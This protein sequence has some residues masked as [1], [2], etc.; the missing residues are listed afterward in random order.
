MTPTE[1]SPGTPDAEAPG[2]E[3]AALRSRNRELEET[4]D[5]LQ[6]G[7]LDAIVVKKGGR[8]QVYTLEGADHPYRVLVEN[9]Q[10]GAL[11][12]TEEGMVLY[13]NTAFAAMRGRP[14]SDLV[15]TLLR[16]QVVPRDRGLF[17]ALLQRSRDRPA[18]CELRICSGAGSVPVLV[19][20]TPIVVN[21]SPKLSVVVSDRKEDYDRLLLQSRMLDA[22]GDAVIATDPSGRIIY[23]S[24]S[25]ARLYGWH[26][27][28]AIGRGLDELVV[29][30]LSPGDAR[31]RDEQLS[32]GEAWSGEYLV[33]RRDGHRFPVLATEAP[34][35]SE[36][37]ELVAVIGVSRDISERKG[38][39]AALR[40]SEERQALLAEVASRL[41]SADEPQA[42]IDDLC[43]RALGALDCDVFFNY[44]ADDASGRLPLNACGGIPA[45]EAARIR[46]LDYGAAV[47]GCVARD[48]CRSVAEAIPEHPDPRTDLVAAYG[49]RAYACHPLI[50][51][52]TPIGTLSFGTVSRDR[53]AADELATMQAIADLIA[54]ALQR[55]AGREALRANEARLRDVLEIS[56]DAAYRRDLVADRYDYLSP[57]IQEIAGYTAEEFAALPL[58]GVMA[59][60][61]P[62]DRP[63]ALAAIE[64]GAAGGT[65]TVEYRLRHRDGT[66]R[67]IQDYFVVQRDADGRP[68][69][70]G[71]VIR[72]ITRRRG[73]EEAL[74]RSNEELQRFAYV[75]SHDLQEPLRTI[76][77]FSQL[78]A[79]RYQGRLGEDADELIAFIVEGGTRMQRLIQD[80]LQ[81]SRVETAAKPLA[82]TDPAAVVTAAA[83]SL[84]EAIRGAGATVTVGELPAV[85]ADPAQLEQVFANLIGNA[86]KY[87]SSDR[88]P[89]IAI[90]A[91]RTN[92][93]VEF[94]VAD[95]G[96][97]IEAEYFD[98]IFEMF[99]RLHTHD[100]YEG[101]GIGLAVVKK[102]V[103][104]H[105]GAIRV[106]STPGEGSTFFV[107][108]PGA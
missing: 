37:G 20:M 81:V 104:R 94:A 5:A 9:I 7:E 16:D 21:E 48:G 1:T 68:L 33:V 23:W 63:G 91:E 82:P 51:E 102:I 65:G 38:A 25:A 106:E 62:D 107:T 40:E 76:V 32:R 93:W 58:D 92:G 56:L 88:P 84:D 80:L 22:V 14:P 15:G 100:E 31:R 75:A 70:R 66:W 45:E 85:M 24:G 10:E 64:A 61:H 30:D 8:R 47:C 29:H 69:V 4:L 41:L 89:A 78:L 96:I 35:Y 36:D 77:S 105:G 83:R 55:I 57:V 97:G 11:T 101:T 99:R 26:A 46:H 19:S 72:D 67:W 74:R 39:E 108:L 90:S 43:R 59:R 27:D 95:N 18:R 53:F 44:L 73:D 3:L 86:I 60:I 71:G 34:V 42:V 98:R 6:S 52:G 50:V 103:E 28:E 17:D 13:A 87:R 2:R 12:L 79:R 49:V 54:V